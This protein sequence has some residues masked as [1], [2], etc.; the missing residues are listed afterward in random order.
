L[1]GDVAFVGTSRVIPRF[2]SYAPGLNVHQ[3]RCGL[4][5]VDLGTGEVIGSLLWPAG[6][7]IFAV[8]SIPASISS[9]FAFAASPRSPAR[10]RRLFYRFTTQGDHHQ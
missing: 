8:E 3:S 6:N 1:C 4:H 10:A 2:A 9:G 7:Q 5:A